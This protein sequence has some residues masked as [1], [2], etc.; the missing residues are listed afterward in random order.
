M[1]VL[2]LTGCAIKKTAGGRSCSRGSWLQSCVAGA[3]QRGQSSPK[4]VVLFGWWT[5]FK[6]L[7]ATDTW[8]AASA[9]YKQKIDE[10]WLF[11][12]LMS[13]CL[14]SVWSVSRQGLVSH[15]LPTSWCCYL[16][17]S[18][19]S[20]MTYLDRLPCRGTC[21]QLLI[22]RVSA[23]QKWKEEFFDVNLWNFW[24]LWGTQPWWH[25]A[26]SVCVCMFMIIFHEA[27]AGRRKM[28]SATSTRVFGMA[29]FFFFF[30]LASQ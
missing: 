30:L 14:F 29:T 27:D 20:A 23:P 18:N 4:N 2:L 16:S 11:N 13:V 7:F 8:L 15:L 3:R 24:P 25:L 5:F 10:K 26:T 19:T 1:P 22:T 9:T 6:Q 21:S 28:L 12:T 17:C